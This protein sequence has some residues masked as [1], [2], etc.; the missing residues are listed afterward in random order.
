MLNFWAY[1]RAKRK[2]ILSMETP[3]YLVEH[4]D[5]SNTVVLLKSL[6][7]DVFG[8]PKPDE[9]R[10]YAKEICQHMWSRHKIR[11]HPADIIT[12][13]KLNDLTQGQR[14]GVR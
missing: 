11:L 14:A 2:E 7:R 8:S 13:L 3:P 4:R 10:A 6:L 1:I 12:L 5:D 9:A